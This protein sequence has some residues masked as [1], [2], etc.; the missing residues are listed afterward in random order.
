ME[1]NGE[2]IGEVLEILKDFDRNYELWDEM[3][4]RF[5]GNRFMRSRRR[6]T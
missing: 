1:K 2:R 3:E 6:K 4:E 5:P